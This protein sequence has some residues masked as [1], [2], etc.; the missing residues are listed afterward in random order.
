MFEVKAAVEIFQYPIRKILPDEDGIINISN[1]ILVSGRT[2]VEQCHGLRMVLG[3]L[4]G[5][6]K[7]KT[8]RSVAL[9]LDS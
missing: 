7:H 8:G 3:C 6:Q 5:N 1:D 9:A 4:Q 2:L